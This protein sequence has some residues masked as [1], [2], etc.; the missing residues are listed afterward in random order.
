[1]ADTYQKQLEMRLRQQR[2]LFHDRAGDLNHPQARLIYERIRQFENHAQEG[3]NLH[4]LRDEAR[5]IERLMEQAKH[6]ENGF[7][8]VDHAQDFHHSFRSIAEEIGRHPDLN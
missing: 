1:M 3:H 4:S 7:M 8:S 5:T 2:D 6:T